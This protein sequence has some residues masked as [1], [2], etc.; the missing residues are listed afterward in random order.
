MD[1]FIA[2]G[3]AGNVLQFVE[4]TSR[5]LSQAEEIRHAG[6]TASTFELANTTRD[7]EILARKLATRSSPEVSSCLNQDDQA[8]H[9]I[10]QV[11]ARLANGLS[12][13]L[14]KVSGRHGQSC[15]AYLSTDAPHGLHRE[16]D[17]YHKS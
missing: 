2:L 6:N 8:M 4:F 11:C 15:V 16:A 17:C 13:A 14:K 1:P 10:A 5:L 9:D 12:L 3:I 7:F